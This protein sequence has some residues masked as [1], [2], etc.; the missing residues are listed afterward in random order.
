M[1][2]PS[3]VVATWS[4]AGNVNSYNIAHFKLYHGHGMFCSSMFM[5]SN[6]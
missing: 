4:D 2:Q 6:L 1:P 3:N 5:H